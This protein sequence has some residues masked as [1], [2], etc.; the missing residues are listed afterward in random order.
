M[1]KGE[2]NNNNNNA[3]TNERFS[4]WLEGVLKGAK[5]QREREEK[6]K[7]QKRRD[8]EQTTTLMKGFFFKKK[9]RMHRDGCSFRISLNVRVHTYLKQKTNPQLTK[10]EG[11]FFE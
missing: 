2:D 4:L 6:K 8:S 9:Y 10:S 7:N 3:Q 11:N 1:K 5:G